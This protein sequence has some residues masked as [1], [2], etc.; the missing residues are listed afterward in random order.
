MSRKEPG[1]PAIGCIGAGLLLLFIILWSRGSGGDG[2]ENDV[3]AHVPTIMPGAISIMDPAQY[4][5]TFNQ[6]GREA[7]DRA[8]RLTPRAA[9]AMAQRP[10]CDALEIIMVSEQSTPAEIQWF[11]DC[12]NGQRERVTEQRLPP[13]PEVKGAGQ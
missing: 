11:G 10:E 3:A 2:G 9:L 6:L 1:H 12:R 8:N 7:F 13:P 5:R 4:P